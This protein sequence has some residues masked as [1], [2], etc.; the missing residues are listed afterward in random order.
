MTAHPL[1]DEEMHDHQ[2]DK[3]MMT[4][5]PPSFI[6]TT[7][8]DLKSRTNDLE[9]MRMIQQYLTDKGYNEIAS[10]LSKESNV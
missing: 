4:M 10:Q 2:A 5:G 7:C 1:E 9:I 3:V 6:D 8:I